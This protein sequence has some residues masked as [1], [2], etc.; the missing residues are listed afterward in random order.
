M[1]EAMAC[2]TPV[3]AYRRG[4]VPEI[5]QQG[6][7]GFIVDSIDGAVAALERVSKLDRARCRRG[8][9]AR[10]LSERMAEEYVA[11]YRRL[12]WEHGVA[13]A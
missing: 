2:G 1:I 8:F 7:T 11:V 3:I 13:A 12:V 6:E 10:F 5:V 4:S 9:E